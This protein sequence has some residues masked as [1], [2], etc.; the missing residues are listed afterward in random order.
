MAKI[1]SEELATGSRVSEADVRG[2]IQ[3]YLC[4]LRAHDQLK[5]PLGEDMFRATKVGQL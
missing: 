5:R 3:R 2:A 1:L 4:R